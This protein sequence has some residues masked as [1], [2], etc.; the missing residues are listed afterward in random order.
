MNQG[1]AHI[2]FE[3][4]IRDARLQRSAAIAEALVGFVFATGAMLKRAFGGA[5]PRQRPTKTAGAHQA[6]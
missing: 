6:S 4:L 1:Q 5:A 3:R 2:D